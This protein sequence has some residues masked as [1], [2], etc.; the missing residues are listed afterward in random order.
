MSKPTSRSHHRDDEPVDS[1]S[2]DYIQSQRK[3][4]LASHRGQKCSDYDLSCMKGNS[5]TLVHNVMQEAFKEEINGQYRN[6]ICKDCLEWFEKQL[7]KEYLRY[8]T[9]IFGNTHIT[10][11]MQYLFQFLDSMEY[12]IRERYNDFEFSYFKLLSEQGMEYRSDSSNLRRKFTIKMKSHR[13]QRKQMIRSLTVSGVDENEQIKILDRLSLVKTNFREEY[14]GISKEV[15]QETEMYQKEYCERMMKSLEDP[16]N[17]V[18]ISVNGRYSSPR[19]GNECTLS[20]I[21]NQGPPEYIE[22]VLTVV[23]IIYLKDEASRTNNLKVQ[24]GEIGIY[25]HDDFTYYADKRISV[26]FESIALDLALNFLVDKHNLKIKHIIKDQDNKSA[27]ILEKYGLEKSVLY[28]SNHVLKSIRRGLESLYKENMNDFR[29]DNKKWKNIDFRKKS[30]NK[31]IR[32]IRYCIDI[33]DNKPPN[34]KSILTV[35][36]HLSNEHHSCGQECQDKEEERKGYNE[37]KL[38]E[39]YPLRKIP[40]KDR[41]KTRGLIEDYLRNEYEPRLSKL[42]KGRNTQSNES[43]NS[44]I[45]RRVSK[46]KSL[47]NLYSMR[48]FQAVVRKNGEEEKYYRTLCPDELSE[49]V[50]CRLQVKREKRPKMNK[51]CIPEQR[52]KKRK[53]ERN[54]S[55]NLENDSYAGKGLGN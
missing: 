38:E 12:L 52:K 1:S 36:H 21:V 18:E 39:E 26:L 24:F 10:F 29:N 54:I 28:D 8:N 53:K 55:G 4:V 50:F 35:I 30:I 23:N 41:S 6:Y 49:N 11:D 25:K 16:E 19:N 37:E 46:N 14:K 20:V 33:E 3:C 45:S 34:L 27:K 7:G 51:N 44:I 43:F 9:S 22:K 17:P 47:P 48:V 42:M 13:K 32:H 5:F 2:Q 15:I 40:G 31:I